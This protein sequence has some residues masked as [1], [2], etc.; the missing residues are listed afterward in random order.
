MFRAKGFS[1]PAKLAI[2]GIFCIAALG[3]MSKDLNEIKNRFIDK[4]SADS[5]PFGGVV[6][7]KTETVSVVET[8]S[9]ILEGGPAVVSIGNFGSPNITTI[10]SRVRSKHLSTCRTA[11]TP[12]ATLP[13]QNILLETLAVPRPVWIND[14]AVNFGVRNS[15]VSGPSNDTPVSNHPHGPRSR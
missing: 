12:D 13:H 11:C 14:T 2:W 7:T 1:G 3:A 6:V 8:V 5:A 10:S 9:T 15:T 4:Y